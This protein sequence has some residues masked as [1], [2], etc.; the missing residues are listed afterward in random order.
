MS[1]SNYPPGV[2]GNEFAIA[3]PDIEQESN[4]YC[5]ECQKDVDG[6]EYAYRDDRW[7]ICAEGHQT[8]LRP[9][10]DLHDEDDGAYDRYVDRMLE[11]VL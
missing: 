6:V 8:D 1:L 2:T 3:G 9:Y 10:T 7:F 4:E 5:E 11:G